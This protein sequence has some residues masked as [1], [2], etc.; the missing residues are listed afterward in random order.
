L[1][2]PAPST[3]TTIAGISRFT[4]RSV[5]VAGGDIVSVSTRLG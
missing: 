2:V 1:T 4:L 3:A 5:D